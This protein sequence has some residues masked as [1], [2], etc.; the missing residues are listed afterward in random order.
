[1]LHFINPQLP[2]SKEIFYIWV[3]MEE[4]AAGV[5]EL[6]DEIQQERE[7]RAGNL[8]E[9]ISTPIKRLN[10]CMEEMETKIADIEAPFPPLFRTA[11]SPS[12]EATWMFLPERY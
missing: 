7:D 4:I 1:M 6:K 9:A 12:L 8:V 10:G 5:T 3:G 11:S 2:G